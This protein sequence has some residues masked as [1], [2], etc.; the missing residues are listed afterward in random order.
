MSSNVLNTFSL[1]EAERIQRT[2]QYHIVDSIDV[3]VLP[4]NSIINSYFSDIPFFMSIDVE[5]L[6]LQILRQINFS[7]HR[8]LLIV[9]ET[10]TFDPPSG[11][12]K[13]PSII[14]FLTSHNYSVFADTRC[15]TIFVDSLRFQG[16]V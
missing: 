15:N 14:D 12:R 13:I 5:G 4:I 7:S 1:E 16:Y 2:T 10:L 8:P 9:S 6:D 11:G 3:D